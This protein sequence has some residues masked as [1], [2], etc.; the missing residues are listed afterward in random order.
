MIFIV[1]RIHIDIRKLTT[2]ETQYETIYASNNNHISAWIKSVVDR[3]KRRIRF[4]FR[5]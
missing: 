2:L 5:S 4:L 1:S 3:S